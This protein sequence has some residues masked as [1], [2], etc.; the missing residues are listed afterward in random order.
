MNQFTEHGILALEVYTINSGV[1]TIV[2]VAGGRFYIGRA[3]NLTKRWHD[4]LRDLRAGKHMNPILQNCFAKYGE[5]QFRCELVYNSEDSAERQEV[6]QRLIDQKIGDPLCMNV[7]RSAATSCDVPWTDERKQKIRDA[8][9]GKK[10]PP[11]STELR[12]HMSVRMQGHEVS[13]VTREKI[14]AVHRGKTLTDEHKRKIGQR[15][16]GENNP[17]YGRSGAL[18][19]LSRAILQIDLRTLEIVKEHA[20]ISEA[21][22]DIRADASQLNAVCTRR[23][24]QAHGYLWCYAD[25]YQTSEAYL[26]ECSTYILGQRCVKHGADKPNAKA[27]L[28]FTKDGALVA[29]YS[30]V[31]QV[32]G[33]GFDPSAVVKA[34]KGALKTA[35][36]F[37]WEYKEGVTT[38]P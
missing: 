18:H 9:I 17:M 32:V 29:E 36:G 24:K 31:S 13:I 12:K 10:M 22:R 26:C 6:E 14:A 37:V 28:Q 38:I 3:K 33:N 15:L 2:C 23:H 1:Y 35:G 5:D 7:N 34:C 27:V 30:Y 19:P 16:K 25:E 11:R 8:H 21:A 4:H 20:G